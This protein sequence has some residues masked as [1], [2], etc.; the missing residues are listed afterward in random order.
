MRMT[1]SSCV[2]CGAPLTISDFTK[3]I[4]CDFCGVAMAAEITNGILNFKVAERVTQAF[5]N[6]SVETR[7]AI[8]EAASAT[9]SS[10]RESSFSTQEEIKRLQIQQEISTTK[11]QLSDIQAEIR[12]IER[13]T[14]TKQTK[15]Q[16]ADLRL[17]ESNLQSQISSLKNK[18]AP[19]VKSNWESKSDSKFNWESK[20]DSYYHSQ[21]SPKSRAIALFLCLLLGPYGAHRYYVGKWWSGLF[22]TLTGGGFL[23]VWIVDLIAI[24]R[25]SFEDSHGRPLAG[26]DFLS[27]KKIFLWF[28]AISIVIGFLQ[29][30]SANKQNDI[31]DKSK[32]NL[33]QQILPTEPV[34]KNVT[35]KGANLESNKSY[36]SYTDEAGK[37][38]VIHVATKTWETSFAAK[39][40]SL[41]K[42]EIW[43]GNLSHQPACVILVDSKIATSNLR[44]RND[45]E[46]ICEYKVP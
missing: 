11:F 4:R 20:S 23:I 34:S 1:T 16:L 46:V 30:F 2:S 28:V 7:S 8:K 41:I 3:E 43:G 25:G 33:E 27:L 24:S 14:K 37:Q 19:P 36:I 45:K 29:A 38:V 10:I 22:M 35:L 21:L 32:Q 42:L 9:Q 5:V 12:A 26:A 17:Q 13:E 39:Q 6:S 40:G 31:T 44:S 15:K 18:L